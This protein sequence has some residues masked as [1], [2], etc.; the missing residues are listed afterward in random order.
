MDIQTK[1][2]RVIASCET[3]EQL[4][5]AS[6]YVVRAEKSGQ[7]PRQWVPYWLG[8]VNGIAHANNWT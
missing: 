2:D 7:L 5:V 8:V 1:V 3:K 6:K 4:I